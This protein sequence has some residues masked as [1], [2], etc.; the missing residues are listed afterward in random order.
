MG[1]T[2]NFVVGLVGFAAEIKFYPSV[3][4]NR[5]SGGG[6]TNLEQPKA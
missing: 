3:T 2:A 6:L 4:E 5:K 1:I